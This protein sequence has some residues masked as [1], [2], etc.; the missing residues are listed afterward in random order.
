MT[1][2]PENFFTPGT[3]IDVVFNLNSLSPI[4]RSSMIYDT[5]TAARV[6]IIAQTSPKILPN[7]SFE[8][9]HIT[10]LKYDEKKQKKRYGVK[11]SVSGFR[12]DYPLSSQIT[13]EAVFIQYEKRLCEVNIRSAFRMSPGKKFSLFAKMLLQEKE[14]VFGK[15]FSVLDLSISGMGLVV[16]K[17]IE[18]R[19]NPLFNLEIGTQ[20][21]LGMALRY[22]EGDRLAMD[23]VACAAKIARINPLFNEKA[24]LI[25][26]HFIKMKPE[27]EEALSRFIHEAQLEEIRQ[28][29]RY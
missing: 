22:P 13:E 25:G 17:K 20:V 12:R 1:D 18:N 29:N 23:K 9:M 11:C 6:L 15:D 14:Y 2:T 4:V 24:G 8:E 10:T 19:T 5:N 16:P 26:L 27:G 7:T 21:T 3:G 28:L